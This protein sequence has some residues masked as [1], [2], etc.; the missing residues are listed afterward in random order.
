MELVELSVGILRALQAASFLKNSLMMK[1]GKTFSGLLLV[2]VAAALGLLLIYLPSWIIS[3]YESISKFG[4]FWGTAYLVL[5]GLGGSMVLASISWVTWKLWGA[6]VM[7]RKRQAR[8]NLNPSEMSQNQKEKEYDEN[9]EQIDSLR[10]EGELEIDP[11]LKELEAKRELQTI[12]I[13]VFGT[14]SS[15]KSSVLNLLAG[16]DVFA[17]DAVG[18][19]TVNRNEIPWPGIDKVILVDTPGIGEIDGEHHMSIAAEAAK[20]AD[21]VLVVVDGP[22]RESEHQLLERLGEMEKRVIICLNKS[23]WFSEEDR[24]KLIG[25]IN[26]QTASFVQESDIVAIQAQTGHRVRKLVRADGSTSEESI[27]IPPNIN[28]L[29]ERMIQV[30]KKNGKELL[31]ANL[32]LQSRGLV[33]KARERVEKTL[34]DK[35]YTIVDKYMWGAGGV[36]AISP[37]PVVDLLAGSAISTKMILD[38]AEVYQQQVDLETAS[39]WLSEMGKNLIGVLGAQ[40]ATVAVSAVVAS[41]VKTVPFAGTLAGGALQ[42]IVQAL[43]T[44]WIGNVFVE[45]FRNEM[46]TPEG[47]LAGLARRHWEK[48][49]TVAELGKLVRTA[50]EKLAD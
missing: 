7:K 41:L 12:E 33:E 42:G 46:Q 44:K 25:Q 40:G 14:I 48:V 13:V 47:G 50:R 15:G 10:K 27:E 9:L 35:A 18:G 26:R 20:D 49:T 39:K 2:V 24:T 5:V 37:F 28:P 6:S 11:L 34:D 21:L 8:R 43:I 29:A 45:F 36:A 1:I 3:N 32:L 22:L 16:R 19:T 38:L 4:Q 17:T 23:D 31:M 30:V